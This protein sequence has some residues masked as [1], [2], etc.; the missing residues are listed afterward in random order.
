MRSYIIEWGFGNK[1]E[2]DPRSASYKTEHRFNH[3]LEELKARFADK[4]VC[5]L[6]AYYLDFN[7]GDYNNGALTTVYANYRPEKKVKELNIFMDEAI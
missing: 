1:Y 3:Q 4:E 2:S 7:P 5:F 6:N